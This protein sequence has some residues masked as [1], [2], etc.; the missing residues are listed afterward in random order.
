MGNGPGPHRP[1]DN[2]GSL[3]TD[4]DAFGP[5]GGRARSTSRSG[6]VYASPVSES[7][8]AVPGG[9]SPAADPDAATGSPS[10]TPA[11]DAPGDVAPPSPAPP[12]PAGTAQADGPWSPSFLVALHLALAAGVLL[13][14]AFPRFDLWALA[15]AGVALLGLAVRGARPRRGAL[16][17]LVAGM[18]FFLP[19]L[20]W[21]GVYVGA[22][23]WVALSLLEA[24][25][26]CVMGALL[27]LAWRAPGGR[28]GTVVTVGCLWVGQEAL[29]GRIPFGGFPWGRLAFSQADSPALGWAALGGA[30][31]LTAV[32]AASGGALAVA[33]A[34][35]VDGVRDRR[36]AGRGAPVGRVVPVASLAAAAAVALPVLGLAVP[37]PTAGE[38]T[39]QVAAVQ[40][41]TPTEG[42]DFNAE[43]RAVLDN[44]ANGTK[45]LAARVAAGTAPQPDLVLWPENASDIDPLRNPDAFDVIQSATD[46][47]GVPV[48]VG[49]V[50]TEP[51][52]HLSNAGILWSPSSS[53]HPGPGLRYVKQHPAPFGEY[54]P[55]RSFFRIFSDKVDLVRRDFVAG[56]TVGV[57]PT[58]AATL[59][60][61]ICFEVAYDGLVR[62][63]VLRG[64]DLL[65]VQTNNATFGETDESVQQLAM[66]RVRAVE[67]GRSVVHISTVGV[68]ALI[69]PDGRMVRTSAHFTADVLQARLPLR[70]TLTPAT[71]LGVWPEAALGVLGVLLVAG[72]VARGR[73]SAASAA[74]APAAALTPA[75]AGRTQ[76]EQP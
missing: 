57:F 30:V 24:L 12:A 16:L 32:V 17:G 70:T 5:K 4:E 42:L 73:R 34:A 20:Y 49:A 56:G 61:V 55:Y 26:V 51:V 53:P 41:N 27:P 64:A 65:V 66:S 15:P 11:R 44:H 10:G 6:A 7:V 18:A 74:D 45:A 58:P 46:A 19:H 28:T 47:V 2:V 1:V 52:D 48:L 62:E 33:V 72:A 9:T 29:R 36:P 25:F 43:R 13:W 71:R 23:P 39:A 67:N 68:S 75:E 59:G 69:E 38:R 54:I 3:A 31:G 63:P 14:L 35:V 22:L 60:D 76:Q 37:T 40:G 50:L 21:S 8:V